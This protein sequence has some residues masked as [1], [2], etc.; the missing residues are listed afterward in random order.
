MAVL[1]VCEGA[2]TEPN[3]FR[4]LKN[5]L[6]LGGL[7]DVQVEGEDCGSAPIS[8]VDYAIKLRNERKKDQKRGLADL[9]FDEVWCVIDVEAPQCHQSLN[10]AYNKA[11][12]N[13]IEVALSNPCFEFWYILHFEKTSKMYYANKEVLDHLKKHIKKYE[14]GNKGNFELVRSRTKT[15]VDYAKSV[16]KEKHFG[17]DLRKCAPSTHVYKVVEMLVEQSSVGYDLL[18]AQ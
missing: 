18:S 16:I 13:N 1:I 8:V 14:K 7:V 12:A 17:E 3:Y 5:A 4:S 10:D 6:R 9:D 2:K 15:A 11:K